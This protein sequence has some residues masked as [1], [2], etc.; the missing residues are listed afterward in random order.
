V[1]WREVERAFVD[2]VERRVF[3]GATVIARRGDHIIFEG[4]FGFRTLLPQ[5]HPM[6]I[7]TVFDLSSLTKVLATTILVMMLTRESRLRLDDKVTRFFPD[8][9]LHGKGRVTFRH[10]LAHC[11]G[12]AAWRPF[13]DQIAAIEKA[14]KVNFMSGPG[15]KQLIFE[16]IH[17]EKPEAEAGAKAIYSDLNFILLGEIAERA[18]G[19]PLNRLCRDHIYNDLGLPATG[20]IDISLARARKLKPVLEM[21]AATEN[22]PSR[23]R[24]LIG[25]VDDDNAFAMGGVAGHAG[26]FAPV[27]DVDKIAAQLLACYHG[28]SDFVQQKIIREFWT[29][30]SAVPGSTW[31]LGWDTPSPG[32]SSSGHRFP[33]TAVGHLGFT[34]TSIWID[35]AREISIAILTN[36]VHPSRDNQA[37]REFRPA[38]HDLIMEALEGEGDG[39]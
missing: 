12:L 32:R 27:R 17:R 26:L 19:A 11:S 15:A 20:F 25:E 31:A 8:F 39:G 4:A 18:T 22:C 10:L 35:P 38:I 1:G 3:P 28:R 9:G 33:A 6:T 29:R 37:I 2:A 7:D 30:D 16:E 23:K 21:F 13:Y 5:P 34:G 14:G 24:L 36:R